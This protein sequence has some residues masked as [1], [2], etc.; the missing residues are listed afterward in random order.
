MSTHT[1]SIGSDSEVMTLTQLQMPPEQ[2][3]RLSLLLE[4]QQA[5]TLGIEERSELSAL[6]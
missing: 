4:K 2:D 5:E 1:I 6:M 3:D